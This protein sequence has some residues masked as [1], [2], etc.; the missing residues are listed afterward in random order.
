MKKMLLVVSMLFFSMVAMAQVVVFKGTFDEA[1]AKAKKENK[2]VM[3]YIIE[4][5]EGGSIEDDFFLEENFGNFI[6]PR[7]IVFRL[8]TSEGDPYGIFN[9]YDTTT[10]NPSFFFI[11]GDGEETTRLIGGTRYYEDFIKRIEK[12]TAPENSHKA[13]YERFMKDIN[14]APEYIEHLQNM[15]LMPEKAEAA[16]KH[17]LEKGS[18]KENFSDERLSFYEGFIKTVN[19][20]IIQYATI[21]ENKISKAIGKKKYNDFMTQNA[22]KFTI[23]SLLSYEPNRDYLYKEIA[24]VTSN[25]VMSKISYV[26]FADAVKDDVLDKNFTNII[27][28]AA[29]R[30]PTADS[31]S[32]EMILNSIIQLII[33]YNIQNFDEQIFKLFDTAIKSEKNVETRNLL[34]QDLDRYKEFLK[35]DNK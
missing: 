3:I 30:V 25:P 2:L 5:T 17:M 7:F 20:P 9:K 16:I 10:I 28:K 26:Q 27:Q 6:N 18:I 24:T 15:L 23:Q 21:N 14:Y 8:N 22:V 1:V 12:E 19:S 4:N 35:Y 11:N 29:D 32:K 31:F 33:M 34:I 13:R